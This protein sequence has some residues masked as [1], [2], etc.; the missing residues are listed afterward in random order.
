MYFPGGGLDPVQREDTTW[1]GDEPAAETNA[2]HGAFDRGTALAEVP[3]ELVIDADFEGGNI[4]L[5][6][7][8]DDRTEYELNIRHDSL[9]PKYVSRLSE[10]H[11]CTC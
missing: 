7:V 5:A 4:E 6:S 3:G 9:N 10:P 2:N 1:A 11:C 8:S